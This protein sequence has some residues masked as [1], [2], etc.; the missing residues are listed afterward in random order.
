M[1][2]LPCVPEMIS[3][4][5]NEKECSAHQGNNLKHKGINLLK[6]LQKSHKAN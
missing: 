1:E 4:K 6:V 5:H 3:E 2:S